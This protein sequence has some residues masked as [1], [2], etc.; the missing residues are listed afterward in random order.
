MN[1]TL[2]VIGNTNTRNMALVRVFSLSS[3]TSTISSPVQWTSGISWTSTREHCRTVMEGHCCF[4]CM[5]DVVTVMFS[6]SAEHS[7]PVALSPPVTGPTWYYTPAWHAQ[8]AH[9]LVCH[10]VLLPYPM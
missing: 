2:P 7:Q 6:C 9:P 3:E 10:P 1:V 8:C 4:V 5:E